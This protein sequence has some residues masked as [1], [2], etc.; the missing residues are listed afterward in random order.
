[1]LDAIDGEDGHGIEVSHVT[2]SESIRTM[3][4]EGVF[5]EAIV[6]NDAYFNFV[7]FEFKFDPANFEENWRDAMNAIKRGV[8]VE[9][10]D[11][12]PQPEG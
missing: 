6:H 10:R 4:S 8:P 12:V 2:V 3:R 11:D 5:R 1:M 9:I 7:L